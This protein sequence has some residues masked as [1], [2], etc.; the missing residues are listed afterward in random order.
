[1]G[2][3]ESA[4][5]LARVFKK[6]NPGSAPE[7]FAGEYPQHRVRITKPF[8]LG[9]HEVTVGQF[10]QFVNDSGYKTDADKDGKGGYGF[11]GKAWERK[12]EYTWRNAGFPQTDEHP[13][14]NVSWNDADAFCRWLSKKEGQTY[15]LPTEAEWE[16]ACRA[17]TQTRYCNG[18]DPEGLAEAGNVADAAAKS[19]FSDWTWAISANDGYVFTAPVGQ[20]QPNAWGM[21]DMHGNA[22][23]WCADWYDGKYY[24]NSRTDDPAGPSSGTSRVLRGGSWG[25]RPFNCRSAYR[26]WDSPDFRRF[27]TGFRVART[28]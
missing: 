19:K 26:D 8:Y 12:P 11:D 14:V 6:Y 15:R 5:D 9:A 21:Y 23:E 27:T 22:C 24:G 13:V 7:Y 18:D 10:R 28:P 25:N 16:Y 17:G 4:E 1:M 20:F 3:R 2:S